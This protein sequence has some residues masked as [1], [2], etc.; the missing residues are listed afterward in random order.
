M[1][2]LLTFLQNYLHYNYEWSLLTLALAELYK[3]WSITSNINYLQFSLKIYLCSKYR[4]HSIHYK[5]ETMLLANSRP[6]LGVFAIKSH[7]LCI[8]LSSLKV[9]C[10]FSQKMERKLQGKNFCILCSHSVNDSLAMETLM[11]SPKDRPIAIKRFYCSS[12]AGDI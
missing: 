12:S 5:L 3:S 8:N 7:H 10:C 4:I 9:V 11:T 2:K 1:V 6:P